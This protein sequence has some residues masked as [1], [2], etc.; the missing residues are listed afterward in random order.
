ML[1][2]FVTADHAPKSADSPVMAGV[3][4]YSASPSTPV[5]NHTNGLGENLFKRAHLLR[6]RFTNGEAPTRPRDDA[7]KYARAWDETAPYE[8]AG[9]GGVPHFLYER[10]CERGYG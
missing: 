8:D 3:M 4:P 9:V 5:Q 7:R 1:V 10:R 6:G 2:R